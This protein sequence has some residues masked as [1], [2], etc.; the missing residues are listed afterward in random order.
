MRE[1]NSS[2][3]QLLW[4]GLRWLEADVAYSLLNEPRAAVCLA[5]LSERVDDGHNN[6]Y[7]HDNVDERVWHSVTL[8]LRP[9]NHKVASLGS[10]ALA[11]VRYRH[12]FSLN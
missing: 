11:S 10:F 1:Q 4:K 3:N 12:N 6:H 2:R 7:C 8:N 9:T 5:P